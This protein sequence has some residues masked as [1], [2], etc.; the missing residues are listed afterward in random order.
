MTCSPSDDVQTFLISQAEVVALCLLML[1]FFFPRLYCAASVLV[2]V[3]LDWVHF[4]SE[5]R[6]KTF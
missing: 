4:A 2:R 1:A 5:Q 3:R 6:K